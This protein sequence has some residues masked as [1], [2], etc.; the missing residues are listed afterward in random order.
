MCY[1][2]CG[3][4]QIEIGEAS[5]ASIWISPIQNYSVKHKDQIFIIFVNAGNNVKGYLSNQKFSASD[6]SVISAL[7]GS[8]A[9]NATLEITVDDGAKIIAVKIPALVSS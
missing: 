8:A 4:V 9:T 6:Q 1:V 3:R 5:S 2:T 7:V